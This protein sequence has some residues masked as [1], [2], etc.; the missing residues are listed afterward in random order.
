M[1]PLRRASRS[2]GDE[3]VYRA[4][5]LRPAFERNERDA[6]ACGSDRPNCPGRVLRLYP[7]RCGGQGVMGQGRSALST[8]GV[9]TIR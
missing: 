9:M 3:R 1:A 8:S 2:L 7:M 4:T 6:E 5:A